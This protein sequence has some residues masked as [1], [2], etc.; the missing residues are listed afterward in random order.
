MLL[1]V[2][3]FFNTWLDQLNAQQKTEENFSGASWRLDGVCR[4]TG[5]GCREV[6]NAINMALQLVMGDIGLDGSCSAY[7]DKADPFHDLPLTIRLPWLM[8]SGPDK[9]LE[10]GVET[11]DS[12]I[13]IFIQEVE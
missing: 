4:W 8:E 11:S 5:V 13:E 7:S 3:A 10:T 9:A 2:E 6:V 12:H 1:L